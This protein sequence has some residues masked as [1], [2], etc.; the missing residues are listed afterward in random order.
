MTR[1]EYAQLKPGDL[2]QAGKDGLIFLVIEHGQGGKRALILH[3]NPRRSILSWTNPCHAK[4]SR[5]IA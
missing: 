2:M 4:Y 5:R 1:K 3:Q